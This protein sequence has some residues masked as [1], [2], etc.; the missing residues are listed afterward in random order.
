VRQRDT[1][2]MRTE[3]YAAL[4]VANGHHW[5]PQYPEPAFPGA[6]TFTGEQIHSHHYRTPEPFAGKR[7]L[8][9]GIGNSACDVAAECSQLA[10][11]HPYSAEIPVRQAYRS[12]D[13]H[14][15]GDEGT[16]T[17]AKPRG[18][19][20][21]A[22]RPGQGNEIRVAQARSPHAVRSPHGVGQPAQQAGSRRHR[23]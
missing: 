17:A 2:A 13:A 18:G 23:R 1:G 20:A 3:R 8:V 14:A 9:L 4:L 21:D 12:P 11:R 6:E 10:A 22:N 19:A 5:D 16:A 15:P 7:V